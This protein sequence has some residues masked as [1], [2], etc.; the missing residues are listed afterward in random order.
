MCEEVRRVKDFANED[1]D[2]AKEDIDTLSESCV[3]KWWTWIERP[4]RRLKPD[5]FD[6]RFSTVNIETS[7]VADRE[8]E[9]EVLDVSLDR[10]DN[11]DSGDA[12]NCGSSWGDTSD[13]FNIG[14]EVSILKLGGLDLAENIWVEEFWNEVGVPIVWVSCTVIP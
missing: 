5:I 2:I 7:V 11:E 6:G 4:S 1:K 12:N 8:F 10:D 13:F 3:S 9:V 14:P